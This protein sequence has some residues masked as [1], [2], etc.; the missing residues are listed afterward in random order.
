MALLLKFPESLGRN[1]RI[2]FK[3]KNAQPHAQPH[4]YQRESD[5]VVGVGI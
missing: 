4:V 3:Y 5:Y 2:F 1:F